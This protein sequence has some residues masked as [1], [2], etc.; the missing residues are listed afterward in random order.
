[1][2][3]ITE[4]QKATIK[5]IAQGYT[6]ISVN[7][8]PIL[9]TPKDYGLVYEDVKFKTKDGL[10]LAAWYIPAENSNKLI[11]CNH[12]ATLNKYGFPGHQEPW[13]NFQ[14]IEV[15]F[16]NVYKAL[17][18]AGYNVLAYDLRNH[19]ESEATDSR[20]WAQ[21]FGDEYK[22]VIAAFDYVKSQDRL[23]NMLLGLFNPCAGGN[24][25]LR[26]MTERPEYFKN[27]KAFVCAQPASINIMS[28]IAINGMGLGEFFDD[29]AKEIENNTGIKLE[30]M[31]PHKHV[32]NLKVPMLIAQNKDDVWTIP[33]DVQKTYDL[34]PIKD[35][36]L[37]WIEKGDTR[38]FIG[39]N[40]FGENP[41]TMIEWFDTYLK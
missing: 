34:I 35:K 23:K 18:N 8:A 30:D 2:A 24:A 32:H 11:I 12:P 26:A 10:E 33:D 1:M 13:S 38:R 19:G 16:G 20:V 31:T 22:D 37:I 28:K 7:R 15:K 9:E 41:E 25:A 4:E 39:Y 21:G 27:V 6:T 3:T 17:H 40:Y 29:F 14:N 5:A 36:K